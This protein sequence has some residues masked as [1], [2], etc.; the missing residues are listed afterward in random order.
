MLKPHDAL[1]QHISRLQQEKQEMLSR[2]QFAQHLRAQAQVARSRSLEA[3][4]LAQELRFK[5]Q[6][7]R[8]RRQA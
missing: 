7:L 4:I 5:A 2:L 3:R 6:E 8:A 1:A